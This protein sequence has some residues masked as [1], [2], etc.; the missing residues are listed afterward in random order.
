MR[1]EYEHGSKYAFWRWK[2]IEWNN[3]LYMR[4]LYFFHCPW[5]TIMVNVF[6]HG[7]LQRH[8]HDHPVD[9]ISFIIWGSYIELT[10]GGTTK[11]RRWFNFVP[12]ETKHRIIK[13]VSDKC[14]SLV[15]TGR[16]RRE[17]GFW[18]EHGWL[19]WQQY[20]KIYHD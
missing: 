17:W 3:V 18:T 19:Q 6:H 11:R 14:V 7:D 15:F 16:R 2:D 1:R 5:F 9:F 10:E 20:Q 8:M 12:A 13:I 4:R